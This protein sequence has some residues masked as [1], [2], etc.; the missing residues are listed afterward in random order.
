MIRKIAVVQLVSSWLLFC[1]APMAMAQNNADQVGVSVRKV[2]L[3]KYATPQYQLAQNQM[4]GKSRDW[5]SIVSD[6]DTDSLWT[7]ELTF[8]YYV[9]VENMKNPKAPRESVFR[10][11]VTYVN[12]EKGRGH[13]S[14]VFMHPSITARFGDIK[15]IAVL[16]EANGKLVAGDSLPKSNQRWW[17]QYTPVDGMLQNRSQTPFAAINFDDY[18][19]VKPVSSP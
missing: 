11:K 16:V 9:L 8:T 18:E 2:E 17:E 14:D 5:I 19:M 13:K 4:K 3:K 15:K 6:Y 10:S 7:D 1:G 12:I